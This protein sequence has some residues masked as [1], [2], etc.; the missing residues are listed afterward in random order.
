MRTRTL[1]A[2][3][4]V[5]LLV[6]A[7]SHS[8]L[9]A[10]SDATSNDGNTF[11][12]AAD[13]GGTGVTPIKNLGEAGCGNSRNSL[14][15]PAGG[16][17]AGNT[18]IARLAHRTTVN[19]G[20]TISDSNQNLWTK[21][22]DVFQGGV[23]IVVFS[24]YITKPLAQNDQITVTFPSVGDAVGLTVD[25]FSG[26]AAT[27][28]VDAVGG[29]S[30]DSS[31]PSATVTSTNGND[32]LYG[33]VASVN[34]RTYTDPTGW[35][36]APHQTIDC[37]GASRR[38]DNHAASRVVTA[39]GTYTYNPTISPG[40][41]WAAALVAYRAASGAP[42]C[43]TSTLA[44]LTGFEY[45]PA[46]WPAT[47][48]A[49]SLGA[50]DG[51]PTVESTIARSGVYSLEIAKNGSGVNYAG[52]WLPSPSRAVVRFAV[53]LESLPTSNVSALV[54][55]NGANTAND[56]DLEYN[57][58]QN[59]FEIAFG[60]D[61]ATPA[62]GTVQ[63]G[64]WYVIDLK[65]D[66]ASSLWRADWRIDG[67]DQPQATHS[68][69][70]TTAIEFRYGS[71]VTADAYTANYDDASVSTISGDYPLGDGRVLAL[72]PNGEGTGNGRANFGNETGTLI[73]TNANLRLD[74][75]PMNSA[76]DYIWQDT[77]SS[78]SYV[79][80]DFEDV[81]RTCIKGVSA[82][83]A[84]NSSGTG[85]NNGKTS[86]FAGTTERVLLSGDMSAGG[87]GLR[88]ARTIIAPAG[89]Y[90]TQSLVNGLTARFGYSTDNSPQPRWHGLMLE[91]A[92]L[93]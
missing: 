48:L 44:H 50:S 42:S 7:A 76:I 43:A 61:A 32:L 16:V 22:A 46:A 64:R 65:V 57:A 82:L 67:V 19:G 13:F 47:G 89:P 85:G 90:W 80:L 75:D 69:A 6:G 52:T 68:E 87:T 12:A 62:L 24:A 66:L 36:T 84:Y 45:G 26:I 73:G 59:R 29:A 11:T 1:I 58:A 72:R 53:R 30:G 91:Y 9:A 81:T 5:G 14:S 23:R 77:A 93:P 27:N 28:R 63:A 54:R 18:L 79:E 17:P 15:V 4:L 55:V 33:A 49:D 34:N 37:G 20:V 10:F 51:F 25:E 92:V 41:R 70:A 71:D 35:T 8:T 38:A 2:I 3:W 40:D 88:Y 74:D 60:T 83:L 39:T 21:D 56:L 86:I 78:T 31:D